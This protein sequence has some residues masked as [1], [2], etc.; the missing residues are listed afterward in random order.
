[1]KFIFLT[2]LMLAIL[3]CSPLDEFSAL[4]KL[5]DAE[6]VWV[7]AQFNVPE[8]GG[9]I[10]SY[11]YYGEVSKPL[12]ESISNNEIGSGFILMSKVKYW[13]DDDLIHDYD[14]KETS[15]ELVFRIEHIA[16]VNLINTPP[17]AG[18]GYEQVADKDPSSES[19]SAQAARSSI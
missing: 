5:N 7:F 3:G 13:G 19:E 11:Y 15:G 6:R 10:E 17:V 8:E 9:E 1:M 4:K 16:T 2:L 12:Y 14:N 18:K